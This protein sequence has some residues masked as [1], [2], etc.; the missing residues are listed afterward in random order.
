MHISLR[1]STSFLAR[2]KHEGVEVFLPQRAIV[3][4][5]DAVDGTPKA[6]G[7]F[8]HTAF[9]LAGVNRDPIAGKIIK[10][11]NRSFI[12]ERPGRKRASFGAGCG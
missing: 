6:Y 7:Y 5:A 2:L 9:N 10:D 1:A 11:V 3:H 12:S 8:R 4:P